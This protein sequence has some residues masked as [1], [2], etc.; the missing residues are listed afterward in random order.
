[1]TWGKASGGR[2]NVRWQGRHSGKIRQMTRKEKGKEARGNGGEVLVVLCTCPDRAA[3][4]RLAAGLV[5]RKL[6]ACVN[7]LPEIRSIYRWQGELNDDSEALM[8]VKTT[9]A[10]YPGLQQWLLENHPYDVPEI[11]A[12]PPRAGSPDY[13]AWVIEETATD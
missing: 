13:L 9:R 7:I 2:R 8:L 4:E 6:A 1:M 5:G 11:L 12:L 3:A 10:A